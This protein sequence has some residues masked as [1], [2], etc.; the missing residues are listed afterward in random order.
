MIK[1]HIVNEAFNY[2]HSNYLGRRRIYAQKF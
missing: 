2:T 1:T